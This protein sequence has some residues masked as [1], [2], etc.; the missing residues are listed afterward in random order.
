MRFS[1]VFFSAVLADIDFLFWSLFDIDFEHFFIIILNRFS[2]SKNKKVENKKVKKLFEWKFVE[3]KKLK[4]K[5]LKKLK[6]SKME[7]FSSLYSTTP[8]WEKMA[9]TFLFFEDLKWSKLMSQTALGRKR[10]KAP[11]LKSLPECHPIF[12]TAGV[13]LEKSTFLCPDWKFTFSMSDFDFL[14]ILTFWSFWKFLSLPRFVTFWKRCR[15]TFLKIFLYPR[16]FFLTFFFS[17]I[18]L[19]KIFFYFYDINFS[20]SSIQNFYTKSRSKNVQKS[21]TKNVQKSTPKSDP[22]KL[23]KSKSKNKKVNHRTIHFN[24]PINLFR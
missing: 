8:L 18:D 22:K 14:T 11:D 1:T 17:T 4:S 15:S 10:Q 13:I 23:S 9:G 6:I 7:K 5:N 16:T 3:S 19:S 24:F 12:L 2:F 20:S 21:I